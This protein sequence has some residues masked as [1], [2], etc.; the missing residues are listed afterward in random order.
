MSR[1]ATIIPYELY[2]DWEEALRKFLKRRFP[3]DDR[4]LLD[5]DEETAKGGRENF[6]FRGMIFLKAKGKY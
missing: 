4:Q 6:I 2:E 1:P 5:V 3:D